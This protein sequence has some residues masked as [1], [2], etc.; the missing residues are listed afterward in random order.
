MKGWWFYPCEYHP[1]QDRGGGT[2]PWAS[3]K[4]PQDAPGPVYKGPTVRTWTLEWFKENRYL[5]AFYASEDAK[6]INSL[7]MK[8][9]RDRCEHNRG[10]PD[11]KGGR[12]NLWA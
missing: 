1:L 11:P 9:L 4:H 3:L 8:F 2:S 5:L 6:V 7:A 10:I 12:R